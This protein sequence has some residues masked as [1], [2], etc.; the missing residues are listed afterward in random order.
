MPL[1][2]QYLYGCHIFV[3]FK[4]KRLKDSTCIFAKFG[5]EILA[6][7]FRVNVLY[8]YHLLTFSYYILF[9]IIFL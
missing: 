3:R 6:L 5:Y 2:E 7:P 8:G 4:R 9:Y 1:L